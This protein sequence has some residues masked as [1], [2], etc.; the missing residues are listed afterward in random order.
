MPGKIPFLLLVAEY[1]ERTPRLGM[2]YTTNIHEEPSLSDL[3]TRSTCTPGILTIY[4]AQCLSKQQLHILVYWSARGHV[5]GRLESAIV[6]AY[7]GVRASSTASSTCVLPVT[8]L[9]DPV[10]FLSLSS[11]L[12][13]A[14]AA[15]LT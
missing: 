1:G 4:A 5:P 9:Y 8:A 15:T 10:V 13:T 11:P 14:I 7:P 2:R 12:L 6:G 3:L